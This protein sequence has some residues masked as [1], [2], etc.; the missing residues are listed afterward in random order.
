[1]ELR[2]KIGDLSVNEFV[3]LLET[4]GFQRAQKR[5][6]E[7]K[8]YVFGL[9]GIRELFNVSHVTAQKYKDGIIADAV[10]QQGAK[11]IVDA[12]LAMELFK[13]KK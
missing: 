3:H 1:M 4:M 5:E 8:R 10:A 12:D 9:K 2:K 7:P 11:I 13:N 6:G